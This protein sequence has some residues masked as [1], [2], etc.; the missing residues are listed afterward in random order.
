MDKGSERPWTPGPWKISIVC[1]DHH[2]S[3]AIDNQR[4]KDDYDINA[5][6]IAAAP[7]LYEALEQFVDHFGDPF[8]T[9]RA[10]ALA[11]ALPKS[12]GR[13]VV[14]YHPMRR[15]TFLHTLRFCSR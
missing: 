6:L 4:M 9:A 11:K 7:E 13:R 3:Y 12:H 14:Q 1:D 15:L 10:G 8:K 2:D 5:R